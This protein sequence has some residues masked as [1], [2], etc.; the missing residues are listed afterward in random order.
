MGRAPGTAF[1]GCPL[2]FPVSTSFNG[3]YKG[4]EGRRVNTDEKRSD[5][6][7]GI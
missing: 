6:D 5:Y 2:N 4:S 7:R 3:W 1:G